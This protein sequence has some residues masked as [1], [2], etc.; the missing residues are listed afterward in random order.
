MSLARA[1]E[2]DN[3]EPQRPPEQWVRAQV[4]SPTPAFRDECIVRLRDGR[5]YVGRVI[6]RW[7][8]PFVEIEPLGA[9]DTSLLFEREEVTALSTMPP[10]R[11]IER[12]EVAERQRRGEPA[13]TR[14]AAADALSERSAEAARRSWALRKER[15][16]RASE[17]LP[18]GPIH[19]LAAALGVAPSFVAR[20]YRGFVV[21]HD[22][23]P[24]EDQLL[25]A[26]AAL[27]LE[28]ERKTE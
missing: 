16:A 6:S 14:S 26:C 15:L 27:E 18:R 23:E 2:D 3:R 1:I 10:H 7:F 22:A 13:A 17:P 24:T 25:D 11:W 19:R 21:E 20:A 4:S 5:H 8:D 12:R 9:S 28:T